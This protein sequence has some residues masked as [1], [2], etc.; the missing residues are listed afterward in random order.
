MRAM[1]S[2]DTQMHDARADG[3]AI[4]SRPDHVGRQAERLAADRRDGRQ[5]V[6]P[7]SE[8]RVRPRAPSSRRAFPPVL[9]CGRSA[10]SPD[11]SCRVVQQFVAVVGAERNAPMRIARIV[12][13]RLFMQQRRDDADHV[14]V[15]A[16]MIGLHERTVRF[17]RHIA[18]M[19]EMD[20]RGKPPRHRRQIVGE[21]APSEPVHSVRPFA[22]LSTAPR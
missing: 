12:P 9:A 5:P 4:V 17:L 18:Q 20:A 15:A 22:A 7:R 14:D 3:R 16:E 10:D 11:A 13:A 19:G 8:I 1:K 6:A 21:P 2:A